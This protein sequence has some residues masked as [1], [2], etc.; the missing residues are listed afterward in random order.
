M[1]QNASVFNQ[2][3]PNLY[4]TPTATTCTMKSMFQNTLLFNQDL[5]A[6]VV[7]NVTSMEK[8]FQSATAF[9]NGGSTLAA[10][11][12]STCSNFTSMFQS[13]TNF[14]QPLNN[15]Y[16][17]PNVGCVMS[18]MFNLASAFNRDI[19]TWDVAKV[20]AFTNMF[21]S[22]TAFNN[23]GITLAA[24]NAPVCVNFNFM[25]SLATNF[26]Q[27][28]ENLYVNATAASCT[29]ASMFFNAFAFNQKISFWNTEKVTT[30]ASMFEMTTGNPGAFNNSGVALT[31]KTNSVTLLT[32]MFRYCLNFNQNITADGTYW[33]LPLV[34]NVSQMFQGAGAGAL[35]HKF[36][37]GQA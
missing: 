14:N 34:T 31:L 17:A 32:N 27:P 10:W 20:T 12:A 37:N 4:K 5:S 26:N 6:W 7:T 23:G 18:S 33:A 11:K 30:M 15:L 2:A 25:F 21:T 8:M 24:W 16:T 29:M 36:N 35:L 1:F 28:L 9:N 19:S 3:L 13:A 22:A